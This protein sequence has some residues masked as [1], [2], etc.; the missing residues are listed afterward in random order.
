M[1]F[2]CKTKKE[3]LESEDEFIQFALRELAL[4]NGRDEL[5]V[6]WGDKPDTEEW[7]IE[8]IKQLIDFWAGWPNKLKISKK[9][10]QKVLKYLNTHRNR[11]LQELSVGAKFIYE[12]KMYELVDKTLV[13]SPRFYPRYTCINVKT[14]K[15]KTIVK[16]QS[17]QPV[18]E[19]D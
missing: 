4:F 12:N 8:Q 14:G 5:R 2:S 19:G 16:C 18:V 3:V 6:F 15:K 9:E 7:Y 1:I 10:Q 13:T 11:L 17:V